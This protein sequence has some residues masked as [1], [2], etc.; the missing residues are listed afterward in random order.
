MLV[1]TIFVSVLKR[2]DAE[3]GEMK[4]KKLVMRFK[5]PDDTVE[6]KNCHALKYGAWWFPIS[7]DPREK[8]YDFSEKSVTSD[9]VKTYFKNVFKQIDGKPRDMDMPFGVLKVAE[10]MDDVAFINATDPVNWSLDDIDW[11]TLSDGLSS[12]VI[13]QVLL[14]SI[15]S[16]KNFNKFLM[17]GSATRL[18]DLYLDS[19][20]NQ[21]GWEERVR[22]FGSHPLARWFWEKGTEKTRMYILTVLRVQLGKRTAMSKLEPL[23]RR[24]E[25]IPPPGWAMGCQNDKKNC[26]DESK[27]CAKCCGL[28]CRSE[29]DAPKEGAG[30]TTA[31]VKAEANR[32]WNSNPKYSGFK[33][34]GETQLNVIGSSMDWLLYDGPRPTVSIDSGDHLKGSEYDDGMDAQWKECMALARSKLMKAHVAKVRKNSH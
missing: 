29:F 4:K 32:I 28:L 11:K 23:T 26:D 18:G 14:N 12:V 3:A 10:L 15:M 7:D 20:N 6:V 33:N 19:R 24:Q 27:P 5:T 34:S 31:E 1:L 25:A 22:N 17:K 16:F 21:V 30:P 8:T 2:A 13:L 9:D